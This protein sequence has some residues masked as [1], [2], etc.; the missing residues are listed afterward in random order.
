MARN[1]S[2][3]PRRRLL[4]LLTGRTLQAVGREGAENCEFE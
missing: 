4:L 3:Q 1:D 2:F